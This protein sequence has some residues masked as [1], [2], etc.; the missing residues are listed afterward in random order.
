MY[1]YYP[2][3]LDMYLLDFDISADAVATYKSDSSSYNITDQSHGRISHES[4]K[5]RHPV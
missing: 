4:L 5:S 2:Y 3:G 1:A